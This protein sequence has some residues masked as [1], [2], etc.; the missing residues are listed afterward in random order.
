MIQCWKKVDFEKLKKAGRKVGKKLG[1][2]WGKIG[3]KLGTSW[4]KIWNIWKKLKKS[5]K[6]VGKKVKIQEYDKD[7]KQEC[8]Q[9]KSELVWKAD[10]S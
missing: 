5:W 2:S 8:S 7:P 6:K 10:I 3:N 9:S 1:K 4:K